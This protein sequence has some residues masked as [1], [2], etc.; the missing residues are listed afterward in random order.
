MTS[1]NA[2][3]NLGAMKSEVYIEREADRILLNNCQEGAISYILTSHQ[4]GKTS[5]VFHTQKRLTQLGICSVWLDLT[6]Y[7][8]S[9]EDEGQPFDALSFYNTISYEIAEKLKLSFDID[10]DID[11]WI[12]SDKHGSPASQFRNFL[13]QIVIPKIPGSF[14]IFFDEVNATRRPSAMAYDF[15]RTL[16][17]IYNERDSDPDLKRLTF[18]LIGTALPE[19]LIANP[20]E[21]PFFVGRRIELNDFTLDEALPFTSLF[22]TPEGKQREVMKWVLSYTYGQPILTKIVCETLYGMS[23][24]GETIERSEQVERAVFKSRIAIQDN[25]LQFVQRDLRDDEYGERLLRAYGYLYD[26]PGIPDNNQLKIVK[27]LKMIGVIKSWDGYLIVRNKIYRDTINLDFIIDILRHEWGSSNP[28]NFEEGKQY[29][30]RK[31][32]GRAT[33]TAAGHK[34]VGK[35]QGLRERVLAEYVERQADQDLL[36]HCLTGSL[37]L[38]FAPPQTGKTS[39]MLHTLH[40]LN[41]VSRMGVVIDLGWFERSDLTTDEWHYNFFYEIAEQV[42]VASD[43]ED[44][45]KTQEEKPYNVRLLEFLRRLMK[46]NPQIHEPLVIFIDGLRPRQKVQIEAL[47]LGIRTISM[48]GANDPLFKRISFVLLGC[49]LAPDLARDERVTPFNTGQQVYLENFTLD[50]ICQLA[51]YCGIEPEEQA[52]VSEWVLRWTDGQPYMA[53]MLCKALAK[54]PAIELGDDENAVRRCQYI[55]GQHL[56]QVEALFRPENGWLPAGMT[57]EALLQEYGNLLKHDIRLSVRQSAEVERL[58]LF[59]LLRQNADGN[60]VL[61]NRIYASSF[62]LDWLHSVSKTK[63]GPV[64]ESWPDWF[65]LIG[66]DTITETTPMLDE[67]PT[68]QAREETITGDEPTDDFDEYDEVSERAKSGSTRKKTTLPITDWMKELVRSSSFTKNFSSGLAQANLKLKPWEYIILILL[69]GFVL[70]T[71]I[72]LWTITGTSLITGLVSLALCLFLPGLYLKIRK[73]RRLKSFNDQF[74]DMLNLMESGLRA[75]YSTLQSMESVSRDLPA[76]ISEEFQRAVQEMQLGVPMQIALDNL[77]RRIPSED[78][79]LAVMAINMQREVGGN[80]AEILS[81]I[82]YTIQERLRLKGTLKTVIGRKS[83]SLLFLSL[84]FSAAHWMIFPGFFEKAYASITGQMLMIISYGMVTILLLWLFF[85]EQ[86]MMSNYKEDFRGGEIGTVGRFIFFV[87]MIL[88]AIIIQ[89]PWFIRLWMIILLLIYISRNHILTLFTL[90]GTVGIFMVFLQ[91]NPI[92]LS[93]FTKTVES[94]GL[95]WLSLVEPFKAVWIPQVSFAN[96]QTPYLIFII[97]IF[98][99]FLILLVWMSSRSRRQLDERE[100]QARLDEFNQRGE[101]VN[102]EEIELSLPFMERAIFPMARMLGDVVIKITPQYAYFSLSKKLDLAGNPA[103]M[104][105]TM[106]L[107]LQFIVGLLIGGSL[108]LLF[109][110]WNLGMPLGQRLLFTVSGFIVGYIIPPVWLATRIRLRQK[111]VRKTMP[112]GLDLLTICVE[113]GLGF[114]AAMAKVSDKWESELSRCFA[115]FIQ[116]VQLGKV[117]REALRD[118]ADR[119]GLPEMNIFVAAVLQSEQLGIS[120]GR[121]LR[122]QSDKIRTRFRQEMEERAYSYNFTAQTFST[123]IIIAMFLSIIAPIIDSLIKSITK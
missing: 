26:H 17:S 94:I 15:F 100:L 88:A 48:T 50:Q 71:F 14:V 82:S 10:I 31:A 20:A 56:N 98:I 74:V 45:W 114:E 97:G 64:R 117:R 41:E 75:G 49:V 122:I 42:G 30:L 52:R 73:N 106:F 51:D 96:L 103:D 115:R 3:Q 86:Q 123:L 84:L 78:L 16:R 53:F 81:T 44:W 24:K 116:E 5:M 66:E 72:G 77:M 54:D 85:R 120:M 68:L 93:W 2:S 6:I 39:L 4:M 34:L 112:V 19:D 59:G 67:L 70:W 7:G 47:L 105:P 108:N 62:N 1:A 99:I 43:F 113:A 9:R 87:V 119:L 110:Y 65:S 38:V 28:E 8:G 101:K 58:S 29:V 92:S 63:N 83:E 35:S 107:L 21:S 22:R 37:S 46:E 40:R 36:D 90:T 76:P 11:G 12:N 60:L 27:Q 23:V 102:L 121:V 33:A 89:F 91:N 109:T 32:S 18:V 95:F 104:G 118:M 69:F 13:K 25:H 57:G 61:A 79:N 80:M 55:V 111:E